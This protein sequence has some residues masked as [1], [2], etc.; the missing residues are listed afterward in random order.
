[1]WRNMRVGTRLTLSF[2]VIVALLVG[3]AALGR[4]G[5]REI[6]AT[7]DRILS[8]DAALAEHSA[9]ARAN[10]VGLRRYE[11]DIFLNIGSPDLRASYLAKWNDQRARLAARL[12]D[13]KKVATRE[14]DLSVL[15][16]M[17]LNLAAYEAG[18]QV[19]VA[20]IQGGSITSAE[21]ANAAIDER[22]D[23]I[24][25]L[26]EAA[27]SLAEVGI[28]RM[29][30]SRPAIAVRAS[31]VWT[32]MLLLVV[33]AIGAS[34]VTSVALTR[35]I[36]GPLLNVSAV[37]SRIAAGDLPSTVEVTQSDEAGDLQ[38]AMRE[39]VTTLS[40]IIREVT[41]GAALLSGAA[42][43]VA[44]SSVTLSQGTAEQAASLE[45]TTASLDQ[46]LGEASRNAESG[47][48]M[49]STA[50]RL[51]EEARETGSAVV[52]AAAA[53]RLIADKSSIVEELAYQTN[54]LALNAAIEAARA[55]EHG[56]GFAVVASE[57]RRLAE[58]SQA[59][60]KEIRGLTSS[61]VSLAE[62]SGARLSDLVQAIQ[63]TEAL[64]GDVASGSREQSASVREI[65]TA[66]EQ[67][68]QVT[69]RTA[70]AAEEL[71][72]TAE[73]VSS[74]SQALRELVG[75]FRVAG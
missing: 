3:V 50:A 17:D 44:S 42:E 11:K 74:Q 13:L 51:S 23:E 62:R 41:A 34:V 48:E 70:A 47:V 16:S 25:V 63:R 59:A 18:M 49:V 22:K 27:R 69:Q 54:L 9:R 73:E 14:E 37:A 38:R 65:S 33:L 57:V 68:G 12:A 28:S 20:Q 10:I 32:T 72:S 64:A 55:G 21:Q 60:A 2:G 35:S 15:R 1:M 43:Q 40:Q 24:R 39:M 58:R 53:I 29:G 46:I 45:E 36:T 31:E 7:A 75:F 6:T 5:F 4:W 56:R 71:S 19:V 52:D 30:A 61:S 8:T 67:L 66:L 26:E